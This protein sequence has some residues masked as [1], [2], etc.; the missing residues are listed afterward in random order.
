MLTI[1][2]NSAKETT[3]LGKRFAASLKKK[4]IV[5]FEGALGGGKTTFIQGVLKGFGYTKHVLSPTF[6]L[7]REY[8]TKKIKVNHLDLY[9]LTSR[10]IEGTMLEDYFYPRDSVSLIEWGERAEKFLDKFIKIE[11]K[12]LDLNTRQIIFSGP[13]FTPAHRKTLSK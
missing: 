4:D 8:K 7:A 10:D 1:T 11:F 9:R 3:A 6:T 12:F 13:A 5:L 2:T